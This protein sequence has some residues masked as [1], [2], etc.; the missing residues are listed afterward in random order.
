LVTDGDLIAGRQFA[1]VLPGDVLVLLEQGRLRGIG[2]ADGSQPWTQPDPPAPTPMPEATPNPTRVALEVAA[3]APVS[4]ALDEAQPLLYAIDRRD[5]LEAYDALDG[6]PVFEPAW[7]VELELTGIPALYA[8]PGG[9]VAAV[10]RNEA[11]ALSAG[12][13]QMW[14]QTWEEPTGEAVRAGDTLFLPV[15]RGETSLWSLAAG[16]ATAWQPAPAGTPVGWAGQGLWL[17]TREGIYRLDAGTGGAEQV[18]ALPRAISGIAAHGDGAALALPDGGLLVAHHDLAD[19]RLLRLDVAGNLLWERSVQ[20]AGDGLAHLA[21]YGGQ[22]AYLAVEE[23]G[24]TMLVSVF[25]VDLESGNLARLLVG[26]TRTGISGDSWLLPG[27]SGALLVNI[28]GGHLVALDPRAA[29]QAIA[30][31][32]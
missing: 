28:G 11:V 2:A 6:E 20:E 24:P 10:G 14:I 15:G 25:A 12:G 21:L 17:Y 1:G 29:A 4:A 13:Q 18:M 30:T 3:S 27:P 23:T 19:R 5:W 16:G 9:G 26:G 32:P 31:A 7:R 22:E 8:L